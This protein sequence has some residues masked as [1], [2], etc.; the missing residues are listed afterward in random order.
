MELSLETLSATNKPGMINVSDEV[1]GVEFKPT[2]VH[3][4][5]TTYLTNAR[6]GSKAQ[7]TRAEVSGGN[8]K[9]WK[10]KGTGRAR[11][12]SARS[13]LWRTG[14]VTF[15][16]KPRDYTQ[17]LN[18][19]MYRV[20]MRAILS[21]LLR[22]GR[23]L[24]VDSFAVNAPKTRELIGQLKGVQENKVLVVVEAFDDNLYLASR[25]LSWV[26]MATATEIDPV[27]LVGAEKV[28]ATVPALK[29]LEERLA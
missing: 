1:F 21:E 6:V 17:K 10:Q 11:A 23:L 20:A 7:K 15:A 3:Q 16:A 9:P 24:V 25:N 12:G 2:L 19:K 4:V 28:I 29:L 26:S 5:V 27:S 22:Q 18:R 8:S 13:P 14:G